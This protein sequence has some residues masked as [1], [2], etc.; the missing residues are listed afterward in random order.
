MT[1]QTQKPAFKPDPNYKRKDI[2]QEVTDTIVRQLEKGV[3]PWHQPW[4]SDANF[5]FDLPMNNNTRNHY[6]GINILLLWAA[7]QEKNYPTNEWAS[8]KQWK[9]KNE[10]IRPDEKGTMIVYYDTFERE[11]DGEVK[12][13]PFL[14]H[15]YVFNRSQLASYKPEEN[16]KPD[17]DVK[18]LAERLENVDEFIANTNVHI[19]HVGSRACYSPSKDRILMPN[20]SSFIDTETCSATEGYYATVLHEL[21]HWTG[22]QSRLNRNAGKKF[23]DK[24]YAVEELVAEFG[25][26]FMC[27]GFGISRPEKEHYASYISNWLQV[28]K[29][30]KYVLVAAASEASKATEYLHKLQPE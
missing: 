25:A 3:I 15:S 18:P 11:E 22:H 20:I 14:K 29:D 1:T 27:T 2:Y 10:S 7:A 19:E 21:T 26:A 28:L 30:N 6:R 16:P 17:E 13:I 12:N 23:G 8:F 4:K 9:E 24:R 5:S